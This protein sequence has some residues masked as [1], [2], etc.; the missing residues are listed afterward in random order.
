MFETRGRRIVGALVWIVVMGVFGTLLMTASEMIF[1]IENTTENMQEA[2]RGAGL[3]ATTGLAMI[4]LAIFPAKALGS[5]TAGWIA[6]VA[7]GL[8]VI[9]VLAGDLF[10]VLGC[11]LGA[12]LLFVASVWLFVAVLR[13]PSIACE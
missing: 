11:L 4:A 2:E 12:F 3:A 1:T 13:Q 5:R 7:G 6:G 9:L 8:T 10:A